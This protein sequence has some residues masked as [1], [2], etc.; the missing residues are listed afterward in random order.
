VA[1]LAVR[2]ALWRRGSTVRSCDY[3][4]DCVALARVRPSPCPRALSGYPP[5]SPTY[6]QPVFICVAAASRDQMAGFGERHLTLVDDRC[7]LR[8]CHRLRKFAVYSSNDRMQCIQYSVFLAHGSDD[9]GPSL[10]RFLARAGRRKRWFEHVLVAGP[11][12][13]GKKLSRLQREEKP[14]RAPNRGYRSRKS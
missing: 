14:W 5:R 10:L 6:P 2:S 3:Q 12:D 4:S 7:A 1:S 11:G 9:R 8:W 13:P